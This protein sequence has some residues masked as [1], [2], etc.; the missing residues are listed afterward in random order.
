MDSV[1]FVKNIKENSDLLVTMFDATIALYNLIGR[2]E[3][4]MITNNS[5]AA[6]IRFTVEGEEDNLTSVLKMINNMQVSG[7]AIYQ[8]TA[9]LDNRTLVIILTEIK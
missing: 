6:E 7:Y 3:G 2:F 9:Y 1:E 4:L 8:C 5:S